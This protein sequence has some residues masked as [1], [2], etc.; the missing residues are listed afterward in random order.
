[1]SD[2]TPAP[3]PVVETVVKPTPKKPDFEVN[4]IV[5]GDARVGK[6]QLLR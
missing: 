6:T 4:I 5:L 2:A 1:M 3:L